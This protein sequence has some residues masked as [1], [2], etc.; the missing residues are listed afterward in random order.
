M[1][2]IPDL[3]DR[4]AQPKQRSLPTKGWLKK[5]LQERFVEAL[6]CHRR[7][8]QRPQRP[9]RPLRPLRPLRPPRSP[10]SFSTVEL[11]TH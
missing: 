10:L 8:S 2:S 9:Q 1:L 5:V 11:F 7:R 4:H 3:L 6:A